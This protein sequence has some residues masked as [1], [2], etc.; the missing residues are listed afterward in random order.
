MDTTDSDEIGKD[1]D[2]API[3]SLLGHPAR[4][5]I[6]VALA[7][8][9]ALP[10]TDL[11]RCAG[12]KPA[13]ATAHLHRLIEG[14]LVRVEIQGRHRYHRLAGPDVAAVLEAMARIAPAA[15]VRSLSQDTSQQ[16]LAEARTCYDHLAGRRG[17]EL[18]DRL[19]A[20][21]ALRTD[22]DY[23]HVL[24]D[25]G[26][27]LMGELGIDTDQLR[28]GRRIF[29]RSCLDWTERRPHLTGALPA[30]IT[31]TFLDDGWLTHR[32]R[33]GLRVAQDYDQKLTNWLADR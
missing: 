18:R 5:A 14:G 2:L 4:V 15:Q 8:G 6:L 29:A 22:D 27:A 24:T 12:I 16:A 26:E 19:L 9:R 25:R 23:D 32:S 17:V 10:A 31:R 1:R 11:A 3:G 20:A 28:I 7:D 21:G 13:T 30:A 33:R